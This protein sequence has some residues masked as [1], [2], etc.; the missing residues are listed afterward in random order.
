MK[1]SQTYATTTF[2]KKL[3]KHINDEFKGFGFP[4]GFIRARYCP[5]MSHTFKGK[6]AKTRPSISIRIGSR[7]ILVDNEG[8]CTGAGTSFTHP[9]QRRVHGKTIG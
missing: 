9:P 3:V 5:I 1:I 8:T 2:L 4:K 6:T 7:D